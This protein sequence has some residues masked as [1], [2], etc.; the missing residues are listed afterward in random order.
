MRAGGWIAMMALVACSSQ[1]TTTPA[2]PPGA[3]VADAAPR[4]GDANDWSCLG[5]VSLPAPPATVAVGLELQGVL[6]EP[7]QEVEVRAC[8]DAADPTCAAGTAVKTTD[9]DGKAAFDV[10]GGF[11]GYFEAVVPADMTNLHFVPVPMVYTPLRHDRVQYSG[12]D[13]KILFETAEVPLDVTKGQ[14]F[15]Q[16]QDC[17]TRA[18]PENASRFRSLVA[19]GVGLS[20]EPMPAGVVQVYAVFDATV[21]LSKTVT[22]TYDGAGAG[23]FMNVPPGVYTIG[24]TRVSNGARIGAQK[25]HVRADAVSLVILAPLP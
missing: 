10:D 18:L 9:P 13:V 20:L 1:T 6:G 23:G 25:I 2:P 4:Q 19:G 11:F 3:G 16:A 8:P 14:V 22:E 5:Q 12:S 7:A 17:T 21:R 24:G 15:V